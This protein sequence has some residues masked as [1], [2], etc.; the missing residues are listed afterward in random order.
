MITAILLAAGASTRTTTP[1][2]LYRIGGIPLVVHQI[3]ALL[4]G[5]ADQVIVVIGYHAEAVRAAVGERENLCIV[6]NPA[7]KKGM[8]SSLCAAL[9]KSPSEGKLLIHPLDVPLAALLVKRMDALDAP[10]IIPVYEG[11]SGHP[12]LIDAAL[13]QTIPSSGV[14]RLDRWLEAHRESTVM[15]PVDDPNILYNANTDADLAHLFP[16]ET[17]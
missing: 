13:A 15:I 1:K 3:E 2:Q 7:P 6:Q 8:F 11:R 5:G 9:G 10:I 14:E 16:S 4:A 17:R 12:V